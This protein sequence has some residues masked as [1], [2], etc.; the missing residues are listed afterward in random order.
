ME[1]DV[2][3]EIRKQRG[4]PQATRLRRISHRPDGGNASQSTY[5]WAA[6]IHLK[7][8]DFLSKEWGDPPTAV[9]LSTGQV[10]IVGGGSGSGST[11][12]YD[13]VTGTFRRA[14]NLSDPRSETT[15]TLLPGGDVLI[16]GGLPLGSLS[17]LRSVEVYDP[18]L[19]VSSRSIYVDGR[20]GISWM[21]S[22]GAGPARVGYGRIDTY[23]GSPAP[24]GVAI[25]S[26]VVDGVLVAEAGVPASTPIPGGRIYA[27]IGG[28]VNTGLALA[29][30][31]EQAASVS[32]YFTDGSGIDF[33]HGIFVLGA[34]QQ[35][36]RFLD[37]DPFNGGSVMRG[38]FTFSSSAPVAATALRGFTNE[39]AEFLITALPVA[40]LAPAGGQ[41]V[42]IPHY[43]DGGGWT[44]LVLLVN[45]TDTAM[46][47]TVQ[48][49]DQGSQTAVAEPIVVTVNHASG[50]TFDYVVPPRSSVSLE[51]SSPPDNVHVGTVRIS[52][53]TE[54]GAPSAQ[55]IFWFKDT[56]GVTVTQAGVESVTPAAAFRLYAEVSGAPGEIG[57]IETGVAIHNTSTEAAS[58][59]LELIDL[60]GS[61]EV[62][63]ATLVIPAFGHVSGSLSEI[64]PSVH[65]FEGVLRILSSS[66]PISVVGLRGRYNSRADFLLTTTPAVGE[67]SDRVFSQVVFPHIVDSGGWTTR[68]VLFSRTADQTSIGTLRFLSATGKELN[69]QLLP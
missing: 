66:A 47:G 34:N 49:L 58:I 11:E 51:T 3:V 62:A 67:G 56:Q 40:P 50:S 57:S 22:G 31:N 53:S 8:G 13:P 64:L 54:G 59:E 24:A 41:T 16:V 37:Q 33:G 30:P 55:A 35:I 63:Q 43:A 10:L 21:T 5:F 23:V 12:L 32:Y 61:T 20:R 18:G 65:D 14:G 68:F 15:A 6:A 69:L 2:S 45:P 1:N 44:T 17:A 39:R 25:F 7:A 9:L 38:T 26:S 42:L 52:A 48:F 27:E 60:D 46:V 19:G 4:F 28:P 36:A 29:N